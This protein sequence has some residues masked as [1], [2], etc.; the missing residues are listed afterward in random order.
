M[1]SIFFQ[2][3]KLFRRIVYFRFAFTSTHFQF[4]DDDPVRESK[5]IPFNLHLDSCFRWDPTKHNVG[6]S[7]GDLFPILYVRMFLNESFITMELANDDLNVRYCGCNG[8]DT[9]VSERGIFR[10]GHARN[11]QQQA[12]EKQ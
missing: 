9:I 1:Q 2:L 7:H 11:K 4:L 6:M 8:E 10:L 3:L 12:C 5:Q